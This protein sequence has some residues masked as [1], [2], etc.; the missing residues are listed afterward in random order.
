MLADIRCYWTSFASDLEGIWTS[1][2]G[3]DFSYTEVSSSERINLISEMYGR[4]DMIILIYPDI[5]HI[6][7][8]PPRR[9]AWENSDH[10]LEYEI[11]YSE[12]HAESGSWSSWPFPLHLYSLMHPTRWTS[13][14]KRPTLLAYNNLAPLSQPLFHS[15]CAEVYPL[16]A[17][18]LFLF[19]HSLCYLPFLR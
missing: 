11:A 17:Y 4:I 2:M 10:W 8:K 12:P 5:K 15:R 1:N 7:C 13:D 6:Y 19:Y 14:A 16:L 18:I 9:P 3:S